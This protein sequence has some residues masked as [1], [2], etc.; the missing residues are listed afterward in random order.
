MQRGK[1]QEKEN[2]KKVTYSLCTTAVLKQDCIS[3]TQKQIMQYIPNRA[4][5]AHVILML[6]SHWA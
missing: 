1:L 2:G 3:Q 4:I 5:G 6:H